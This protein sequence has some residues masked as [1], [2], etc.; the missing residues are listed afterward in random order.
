MV[1][2]RAVIRYGAQATRMIAGGL[3]KQQWTI[4]SGGALGI[5]THAHEAALA[6]GAPTIA[7]AACG[8][9]RCY[10]KRN[11]GLFHRIVD[12]GGAVVTEYPPQTTPQRHRFLTRNRLVAALGRGTV[13]VEAAWRSGA[14]NTLSWAEGLG[15]VCMAVPGP[16]THAGSLGRHQRIRDGAAELVTSAAEVR[17]LIEPVGASDVQA[18]Y[19]LDFSGDA[20]QKLSRNEL[21]VFDALEP[22]RGR[23][24]QEVATTA[25]LPLPLTVYLLVALMRAGLARIDGELWHRGDAAEP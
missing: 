25:G 23:E 16:V 8:I 11:E 9:D 15:R 3:A 7:V 13:V 18:Q 19:E 10:P 22:G 12:S 1:G 21:R 24:T 6:H 5:D 20:V 4:V 17:E 14:L 2:T